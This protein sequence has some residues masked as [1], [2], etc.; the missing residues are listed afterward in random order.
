M[1]SPT[2]PVAPVTKIRR[3]FIYFSH[4]L[5]QW[6]SKHRRRTPYRG[7]VVDISRHSETATAVAC[8]PKATIAE[9]KHQ[10]PALPGKKSSEPEKTTTRH[11]SS[12]NVRST[13]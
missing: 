5:P 13:D 6:R 3:R 12:C 7:C 10:S 8:A 9:Q 4:R 2:K 1:A 11:G